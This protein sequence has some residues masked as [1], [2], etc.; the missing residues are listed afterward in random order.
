MF[1]GKPKKLSQKGL[2]FWVFS[3]SF[4]LVFFFLVGF[5]W[6]FCGDFFLLVCLLVCFLTKQEHFSS[7]DWDSG[8]EFS[9]ILNTHDIFEDI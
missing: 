8:K 4:W 6:V 2:L 1:F 7:T 9:Q 3:W 5:S